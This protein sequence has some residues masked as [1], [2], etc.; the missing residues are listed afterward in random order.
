MMGMGVD[1]KYA[2]ITS[3]LGAVIILSSYLE[4]RSWAGA[5]IT[6]QQLKANAEILRGVCVSIISF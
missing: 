1:Q 3:P 5:R 4:L 6:V 2:P